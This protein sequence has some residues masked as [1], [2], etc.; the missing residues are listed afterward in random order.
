MAAGA[1]AGAGAVAVSAPRA[2]SAAL[3]KGIRENKDVHLVQCIP[4]P[5]G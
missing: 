2:A 3:S 1:G 5:P 4:S